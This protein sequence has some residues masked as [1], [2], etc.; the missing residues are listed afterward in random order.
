M[1]G[2][3][4]MALGLFV[5]FHG[6]VIGGLWFGFIGLFLHGTASTSRREAETQANLGGVKVRDAMDPSPET[7][8]PEVSVADAV[9]GALLQ[10]GNRALLVLEDGKLV[11]I[12]TLTDVKGVSQERW[13]EVTVGNTMTRAPLWS[14]H[15]D[16]ELARGL[17]LLGQHSLNQAPVLDGDRL[18][19]LL[20]RSGVIRYVHSRGELGV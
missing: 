14:V 20:T 19:G 10:R 3:A 4:F 1:V 13:R 12:M 7:I 15:P 2:I 5:V 11:G 9:F 18:V 6:N 16:D 17:E 8:G